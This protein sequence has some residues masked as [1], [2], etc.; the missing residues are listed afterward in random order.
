MIGKVLPYPSQAYLKNNSASDL[1]LKK[2]Q[3]GQGN[4]LL[5]KPTYPK[6]NSASDPTLKKQQEG[7]GN[8]LLTP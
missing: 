2:Q 4:W 7:Q 3:E 6:N 1:T 5:H 8:W